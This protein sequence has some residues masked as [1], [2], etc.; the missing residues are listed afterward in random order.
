VHDGDAVQPGQVLVRLDDT[1]ARTTLQGL[2]GQYWDALA[3]EARQLAQR[4][5]PTAIRFAAVLLQFSDP[6]A[7]RLTAAQQKIFETR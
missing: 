3:A 5:G 1:K 4:D 7:A 6:S 2:R